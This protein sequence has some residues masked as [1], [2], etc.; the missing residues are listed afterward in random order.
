M[1]DIVCMSVLHYDEL[2]GLIRLDG[3]G[4]N[5]CNLSLCP[6]QGDPCPGISNLLASRR[7][8]LQASL[9]AAMRHVG[10]R[11]ASTGHRP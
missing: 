8:R 1:I 11:S 10:Y 6:F 4:C 7:R 9:A 5:R 2:M 3:P